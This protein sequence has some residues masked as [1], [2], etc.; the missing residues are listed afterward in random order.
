VEGGKGK[1]KLQTEE[2]KVESRISLLS[3]TSYMKL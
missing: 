2:G 1:S 3:N